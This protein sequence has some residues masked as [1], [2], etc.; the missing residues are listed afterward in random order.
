MGKGIILYQSKYGATK[1]YADW[2]KE[3]TGYDC[4]ETKK[5]TLSLMQAY[6]VIVLGGGVYA[7][8]IAGLQ[9]LK[10]N[11]ND[12]S[13][14]KIA[15]FAVGASPYDEKA[16]QQARELHFKDAMSEIPLFYCRGAW[17]EDKM[18]F[19]HRT[20]CRMLQKAVAKQNPEEYEPWQR[21]LMEA[22][23]Q[24]CD[25]TDKRNLEPLLKY[26]K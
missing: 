4:I 5:A 12:L 17:D 2:L 21:A 20:L 26:L 14:K 15:V 24:K 10:K 1:K 25:W 9:F 13:G 22:W 3:E 8:G 7:S 6:D 18:S 23:G 16:I 19:G 11:I